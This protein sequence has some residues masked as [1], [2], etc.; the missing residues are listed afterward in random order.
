MSRLPQLSVK[1]DKAKDPGIP[2]SLPFKEEILKEAQVLQRRQE[3]LR[4][5]TRQRQ[6]EGRQQ[7]MMSNRDLGDVRQ[8]A[9]KRAAE[10]EGLSLLREHLQNT[11]QGHLLK[12]LNAKCHYQEF[13]K[14]V[15]G[16]DVVLEVLDARD[17]LG[18]R[19][20]QLEQYVLAKRKRLVLVLNKIDLIPRENLERWLKHLRNELPTLAFKA[21]TQSQRNN[22]SHNRSWNLSKVPEGL[23]QSSRCLGASLLMKMLGNYCRNQGIQT[24]IT[25]GVVGYPNVGKSSIVNSLKRSRACTVGAVPGVTKVMQKVQLDKHV[26]LLDSPGVVMAAQGASQAS[27]AL[28]NAKRPEDLEDPVG[29][30]CSILRRASKEQFMLHYRLPDFSTPE[31]C[32]S[33]LAKRMGLLRKGGLPNPIAAAKRILTDWNCGRIKYYTEPPAM[34][35]QTTHLAAEIVQ[36]MAKEFDI[37][38]LEQEEKMELEAPPT[39]RHLIRDCQAPQPHWERHPPTHIRPDDKDVPLVVVEHAAAFFLVAATF[40]CDVPRVRRL[41]IDLLPR[42][43]ARSPQPFAWLSPPT[44]SSWSLPAQAVIVLDAQDT[45]METD[46][47]PEGK[48]TV[49]MGRGR[50]KHQLAKAGKADE[51][52]PVLDQQNKAR[53]KE[54]KKQIKKRKRNE[55]VATTLA[56]SLESALSSLA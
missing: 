27:V 11:N 14:V 5:E 31:E 48:F 15:E 46:Q 8:D 3:E 10:F 54:F 44:P 49:K 2:N 43:S 30:A 17:P 29:P 22:L 12:E 9:E 33:L 25:V 4:K 21:S 40:R 36:S 13:R 42:D 34:D 45:S 53:R 56:N 24:C 6:K 37:A 41:R 35:Q 19:S 50:K 23:G 20:P 39:V 26:S 51:A 7:L 18:T 1:V 52:S 28:R 55:K 47:E 32:F 16:A 38:S